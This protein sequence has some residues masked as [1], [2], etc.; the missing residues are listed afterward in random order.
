MVTQD[1][2]T[3]GGLIHLLGVLSLGVVS[4]ILWVMKKDESPFIDFHG[5]EYLN[6]FISIIIYSFAAFLLCFVLIGFVLL[7]AILVFSIVVGIMA[8]IKGFNG[9]YFQYPLTIRFIK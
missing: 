5:K 6:F 3:M 7:P 8:T 2:K 4:I 1:E 9:E